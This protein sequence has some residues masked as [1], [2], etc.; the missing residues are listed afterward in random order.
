MQIYRLA[1]RDVN[2]RI[3]G[4]GAIKPSPLSGEVS[5]Q[6]SLDV[7]IY[8]RTFAF[9]P[10]HAFNALRFEIEPQKPY[11]SGSS[12]VFGVNV[13]GLSD[14]MTQKPRIHLGA[15]QA[16]TFVSVDTVITAN[17]YYEIALR[18]V[19]TKQ[20]TRVYGYIYLNSAA[21]PYHRIYLDDISMM[22]YNYGSK[23]LTAPQDS[24]R[25]NN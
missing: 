15:M 19:A 6:D 9:R 8:N 4:L 14:E 17:G 16:N 13:W 20:V 21:N 10:E 1:L 25:L 24:V 11:S 7:W 18:T 23:A 3:E 2:A 12:Y 5:A 22:K